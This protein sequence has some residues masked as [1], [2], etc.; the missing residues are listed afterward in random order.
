MIVAVALVCG[1]GGGAATSS[2]Q[3]GTDPIADDVTR[4]DAFFTT[5]WGPSPYNDVPGAPDGYDDCGPTSLVMIAAARGAIAPPAPATAE[6]EIRSMRTRAKGR[7]EATSSGTPMVQMLAAL[8]ALHLPA[9]NL[10][11]AENETME[12]T[13]NSVVSALDVG[14]YLVL[15]GRPG[16]AWGHALYAQNAYLHSYAKSPDDKLGHWVVVFARPANNT[17][18]V[19]DPMCTSGV[20]I[21]TRAQLRQYLQDGD[22]DGAALAVGSSPAL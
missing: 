2:S 20:F 9:R 8:D 12:E 6:D 7:A 10:R 15:A 18:L 11:L 1:C 19:A 22:A 14:A 4:F 13:M 16:N 21:A 3:A 5:Q 17:F